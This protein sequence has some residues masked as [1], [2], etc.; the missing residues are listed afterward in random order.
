[1]P[2]HELAKRAEAG[3]VKTSDKT[4]VQR[5]IP[6]VKDII[7]NSQ[8]FNITIDASHDL[9]KTALTLYAR[10]H[11]CLPSAFPLPRKNHTNLIFLTLRLF[12][13]TNSASRKKFLSH[14]INS[15]LPQQQ[16]FG[17]VSTLKFE[18]NVALKRL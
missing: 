12:L 17:S 15:S 5:Q 18:K 3:R 14:N 9:K 16:F 4:V 13:Y 7:Y 2:P 11:I 1:M 10:G 6:G 8:Y